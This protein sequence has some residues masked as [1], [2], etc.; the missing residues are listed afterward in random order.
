MCFS[1][2]NRANN[3]RSWRR[4]CYVIILG[5]YF[6]TRFSVHGLRIL[7]VTELKRLWRLLCRPIIATNFFVAIKVSSSVYTYSYS[8]TAFLR[9]WINSLEISVIFGK[10]LGPVFYF[11]F[12]H[13]FKQSVILWK[14]IVIMHLLLQNLKIL[15]HKECT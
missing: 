8:Y 14:L 13:S 12:A 1:H 15:L 5:V 10:I 4:T 3:I 6:L 9:L 2:W 7:L 11:L